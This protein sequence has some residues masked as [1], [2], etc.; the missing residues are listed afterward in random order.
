MVCRIDVARKENGAGRGRATYPTIR[1][2]TVLIEKPRTAP[3]D[4]VK[5]LG[6]S[7]LDPKQVEEGMEIGNHAWLFTH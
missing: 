4:N 1:K 5:L 7:N 2:H 3:R 6:T